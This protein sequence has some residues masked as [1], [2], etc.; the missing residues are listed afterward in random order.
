ML[1]TGDGYFMFGSPLAALWASGHYKLP[2][3]TVVFVNKSYS[4]GTAGLDSAYPE[5]YAASGGYEGGVFDPP[6]NFAK[7][8][9]AANG[10]GESVSD[11]AE[12][13]P[14]LRRGLAE[15]R[16]GSPAVIAVELPTLPDELHKL[17]GKR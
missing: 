17:G 9:E 5:G 7:L 2:F 16:N 15:V 10:Y 11:P 4:T 8:A 13:G 3:L 12:V 6:P 1:V 14:A